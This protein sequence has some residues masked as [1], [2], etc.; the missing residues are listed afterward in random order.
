MVKAEPSARILGEKWV[1]VVE[2]SQNY[3]SSIRQFLANMYVKNVKFVASAAEARKVS[4]QKNVG[5]YIVEWL[6][7][8]TNG[9]QYRKEL[10]KNTHARDVPFLLLSMENLG[11]DV[12]L[13][14]EVN[15]DGYL[16]KPFSYEMFASK[17]GEVLNRNRLSTTFDSL[18]VSAEKALMRKDIASAERDFANA[19][20]LKPDSARAKAGLARVASERGNFGLALDLVARAHEL[21][22]E[23]I[24]A[25]RLELNIHIARKDNKNVL[26]VA[27]K[28]HDMSPDNPKY[29]MILA[30]TWQEEGDDFASEQYFKMTIALSPK[31][32]LAYKGLG[33]IYFKKNDFPRSRRYFTK[34]MD[35][36]GEDIS[37]LNGLGTTIIRQG[38]I[39]EGIKYYL[40]A[41]KL[42]SRNAK[43]KFNLGHAYEKLNEFE[44]ALFYLNA[45][46]S[47]DSNFEKARVA[48]AR[49][50]AKL[51]N[52]Q[53]S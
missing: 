31:L 26:R 5:L 1:V 27:K 16:L 33:E 48:I 49:I 35:L 43:V 23:F 8:G 50:E 52:K 25:L 32:A 20:E 7:N 37:V 42:D 28:I 21:N 40:L 41:L 10:L 45:A 3:R 44:Q 12:V 29:T 46:L 9:L 47:S 4:L 18:L 51:P 30:K 17:V 14:S 15:I 13:A 53:A 24:E 38:N 39:K 11:S 22:P 34:S 36:D 19:M 2:P 6:M